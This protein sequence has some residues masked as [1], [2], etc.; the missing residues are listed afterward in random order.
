MFP[1]SLLVEFG[2]VV[3]V[4]RTFSYRVSSFAGLCWYSFDKPWCFRLCLL[5]CK[6]FFKLLCSTGLF[7]SHWQV[8][9]EL[10]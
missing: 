3:G 2:A 4:E 7:L 9:V 5:D 6:L 10:N 1:S 8:L